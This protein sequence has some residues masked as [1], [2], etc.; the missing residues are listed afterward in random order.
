MYCQDMKSYG[1]TVRMFMHVIDSVLVKGSDLSEIN[2][3][4]GCVVT[5]C[6]PCFNNFERSSVL[7]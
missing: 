7:Y 3:L 4:A 1:H 2:T 5:F 6:A